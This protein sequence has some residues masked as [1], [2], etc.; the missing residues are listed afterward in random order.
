MIE[1]SKPQEGKILTRS[2]IFTE[3]YLA[4]EHGYEAIQ[5]EIARQWALAQYQLERQGE[6]DDVPRV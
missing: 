2:V 5:R 6:S 1:E 4:S 3:A